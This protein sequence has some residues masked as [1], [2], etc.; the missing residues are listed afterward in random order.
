MDAADLPLVSRCAG[1]DVLAW[2]DGR[3]ISRNAFLSDVQALA[4]RLPA[5]RYALNLCDDRYL[6]MLAFCAVA[7]RGQTNLL[8]PNRSENVLREIAS[9][10]PNSYVLQDQD[11]LMPGLPVVRV[12]A[13]GAMGGSVGNPNIAAEHLTALVFTSG[14]TGKSRP[15]PKLWS[16]LV[17]STGMARERFL[18]HLPTAANV[19]VTVPP[20][21]MYGLETSVLLALQGGVA[22]HSGRPFFPEDVHAALE[23]VPKPRVLVTTPV[24]L[25]ACVKAGVKLPVTDFIISATAP[26]AADL[27]R[28]AENVFSTKVFE[29]YGCTETGSIASRH[30]IDGDP[31]KLYEGMSIVVD[32]GRGTV[33][34]P[35]LPEPV[36][37]ADVIDGLG[38]DRFVL[39]GRAADMIN[40]AG[41]RASLGDL[42]YRL[43]QIDGVVDGVIF[44]P[45]GENGPVERLAALVVAPTLTREQLL[46]ALRQAVDPVFLPRPLYLVQALPRNETSKL[47]RQALLDM[48][49]RESTRG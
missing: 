46:G 39:R 18:A 45:D 4:Q 1:G 31:W 37:L 11:E 17:R 48:L 6:F 32:G 27:A 24:H 29:I 3:A 21:H 36:R 34:G 15:N 22:V 40:I 33:S 35:Q 2:R 38:G 8:P 19:V 16:S 41:K 30:T 25:R 9:D 49:K 10:Y 44:Q 5:K 43:Q 20:Q 13:D 47:P 14:S 7:I 28:D 12:S 42:N 23:S 26:L